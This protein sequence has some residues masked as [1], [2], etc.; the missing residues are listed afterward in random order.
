[1]FTTLAHATGNREVKL[2]KVNRVGLEQTAHEISVVAQF[3]AR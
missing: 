3:G 2:Q 1:M